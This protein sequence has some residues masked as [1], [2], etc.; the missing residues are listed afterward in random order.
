MT[1]RRGRPDHVRRRPPSTG[2]PATTAR[3]E[4]PDRRRVRQHKGMSGRRRRAPLI[5]RALLTLSVVILAGAA[6]VAARGGIDPILSTLGS[7][8]SAA[9]DRLTATPVPTPS[10]VLP[11]DSPLIT[12]PA[13]PYTRESAVDL[14]ITLPAEVARDPGAKVR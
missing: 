10:D 9:I 4:A 5:L 2:R 8:V 7:G 13:Q 1:T 12:G 14:R 11:T 3:V 6:F